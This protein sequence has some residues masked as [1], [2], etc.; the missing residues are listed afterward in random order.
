ME[1]EE[2]IDWD[3]VEDDPDDRYCYRCDNSGWIVTC[4]DDLC[5]SGT[6]GES[7]IHGDGDQLCPECKG[8]NA[9]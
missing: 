8:R 2:H 7:C 5:R 1:S 4:C 9:F 6:P 3:D